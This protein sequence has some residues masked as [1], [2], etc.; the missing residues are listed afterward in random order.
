MRSGVIIGSPPHLAPAGAQSP[1]D[2]PTRADDGGGV[3]RVVVVGGRVVLD[4]RRVTIHR[5]KV[6]RIFAA[7]FPDRALLSL[8]QEI[9]SDAA[10]VPRC[11]LR[12]PLHEQHLEAPHHP[13]HARSKL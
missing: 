2:G 12:W 9:P 4:R 7:T 13:F 10:A 6:A 11:P 3:G 5:L 8:S 1:R